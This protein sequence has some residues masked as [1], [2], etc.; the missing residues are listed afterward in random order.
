MQETEAIFLCGVYQDGEVGNK[1]GALITAV[2]VGWLPRVEGEAS[3]DELSLETWPRVLWQPL[4]RSPVSF[5][6][7]YSLGSFAQLR[8]TRM[9][10]SE[11]L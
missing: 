7:V 11:S 3:L 5:Q 6:R 10:K 9:C 2:K 4:P 8:S 1:A